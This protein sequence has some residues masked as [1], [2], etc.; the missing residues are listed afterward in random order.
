[1]NKNEGGLPKLTSK[2]TV[3]Y[4]SVSVMSVS[5]V[6]VLVTSVLVFG[7]VV[8]IVLVIR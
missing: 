3:T 8:T 2:Q 6:S 1:V 5:V 4:I 7:Q